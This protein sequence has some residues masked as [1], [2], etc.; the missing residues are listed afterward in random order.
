MGEALDGEL[1]LVAGRWPEYGEDLAAA[2]A[3]GEELGVAGQWPQYDEACLR[4]ASLQGLDKVLRN[5]NADVADFNKAI[6][7]AEACGVVAPALEEARSQVV[8]LRLGT[9]GRRKSSKD[10]ERPSTEERR[11]GSKGILK[12]P[13]VEEDDRPKSELTPRRSILKKSSKERSSQD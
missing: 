4:L 13:T 9:L 2:V 11:S 7:A 6:S 1:V 3:K 12:K 10:K 8:Q 5:P